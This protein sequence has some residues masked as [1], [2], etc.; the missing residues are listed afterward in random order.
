[1]TQ[2]PDYLVFS[3]KRVICREMSP[4]IAMIS[5]KNA[6]GL[7]VERSMEAGMYNRLTEE[8]HTTIVQK[9]N[10]WMTQLPDYLVFSPINNV[11]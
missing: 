3:P 8:F 10:Q 2:L 6:I 4:Q 11:W 1:M 7:R 9:S 5:I